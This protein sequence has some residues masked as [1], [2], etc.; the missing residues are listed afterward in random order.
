[1]QSDSSLK[2][3]KWWFPLNDV[4]TPVLSWN[5][6]KGGIQRFSEVYMLEQFCYIRLE[7]TLAEYVPQENSGDISFTKLV[8]IRW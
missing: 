8:Q 2:L 1:M 7:N 4:E 3:K 5:I 6:V